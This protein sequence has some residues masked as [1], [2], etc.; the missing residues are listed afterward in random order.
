MKLESAPQDVTFHGD[1]EQRDVAIGDVAFILDMFA[2]KV[3]S[4][5]E[6]AVIR[7]LACN[8]H[9]SHVMAGTTDV[10]FDVHLP[11]QL[12]PWF[13][14]RDYGTGLA[15][16]DIANVYGAIGVST[17]RD[18]NEVIGCFGIGSLSPYSMCDSFTVKSYLDGIVRTYQCMRDEKRQPKVIPLG[19]AP[20]DEPN[21]LEV[22][23]TVNGKVSEFEEEA[24]H[25][26]MFWEGTLPKIN[27]QHVIRKCQDL[28]DK[29]VFKGDDFGL[30]P[31]WG[32]MYALMGNIAYKIP[33]QLDEFDVDGYLKFDLGELEFDTARE[34]LSM[35]DKTKAA[36]KAKFASVK[37][38]LT[39]I[40]VDQ[41]EAEDTPFKKAALAETLGKGQLGRFV[42]RKNLDCYALPEPAESVTYWQSK[43]R[44]SE[45]YHTKNIS[46]TGDIK[47]YLHKDRMQTRIKSYLKDMSSGHTMYIFKDLAQAQECNIPVDM[48]EDLDD[49]PKV[50]RASSGT[51]SK[52]KT[53]RFVRK[54]SWGWSDCDYWSETEIELDGSEIVYVEVNRNKPV[55]NGLNWTNSNGQINSTLKTANG[56]IGEINL[57]GLK[58][59]FLKTAAFRKGN[60]I[61]LDDYLRR[62]YAKKAPKTYFEFDD[63]DLG[64]FKTINKN[65][66]ND[67][68]REIVELAESCKNDEIAGI[69][70]RLGVA[71]EMTKDTML[72][73]MMDDWNDR[74][75]M[76][77]LLSEWEIRTN[78]EIVAEYISGKVKE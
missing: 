45:K 27:N 4:N 57:I 21:G 11:T 9:D 40:A 28:R 42:G 52:C 15:D 66:D 35:T 47:Y 43:Y 10:P 25:V 67:E 76:M 3:Y 51:T 55:C 73:E 74:H 59:A 49:L 24:G 64:K 5:K 65:I 39:K 7:E 50:T 31:S 53:L 37:D 19:S 13:S 38:S 58:T 18:S 17:K 77:T 46:A 34:N 56:H 29:Y 2:D 20:T 14:L 75:K 8:A 72:Q 41:I 12:E 61:H 23:L 32:S 30:T 78:K 62:E 60:F 26:F 54:T 63:S 22:K 16:E 70:K 48:L 6:R 68:V 44:G 71:V 36:L 33:N 69:C 1:F